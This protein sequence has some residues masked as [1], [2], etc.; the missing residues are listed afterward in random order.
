M[1]NVNS[2]K[3]ASNSGPFRG[4]TTWG[5]RLGRF[6]VAVRWNVWS[7]GVWRMPRMHRGPYRCVQ[8]GPF[9]VEW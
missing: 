1:V 6:G 5:L 7:G 8:L 9:I 4:L 2:G 3:R